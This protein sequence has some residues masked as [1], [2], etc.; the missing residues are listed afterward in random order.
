MC[1]CLGKAQP[2]YAHTHMYRS[3]VITTEVVIILITSWQNKYTKLLYI[4]VVVW[5]VCATATVYIPLYM[6]CVCVCMCFEMYVMWPTYLGL[7]FGAAA[8]NICVMYIY[9]ITKI[10]R[11][12]LYTH[13]QMFALS[14]HNSCTHHEYMYISVTPTQKSNHFYIL[15]EHFG[16]RFRWWSFAHQFTHIHT[17]CQ[18][19]IF[20]KAQKALIY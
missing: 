8:Q 9:R 3:N 17:L 1:V 20:L 12:Y 15:T 18:I 7:V 2:V 16:S 5:E 19:V 11:N 14:L 4:K 6:C 10:W 13:T